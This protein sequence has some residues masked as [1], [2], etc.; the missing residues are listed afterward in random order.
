MSNKT[1]KSDALDR[2]LSYRE[3]FDAFIRMETECELLDRKT[4]GVCVWK[5]IRIHVYNQIMQELGLQGASHPNLKRG[6][7]G[8]VIKSKIDLYKLIITRNA[9]TN[10]E[11][12]DLLVF[13]HR[14]RVFLDGE[15]VEVNTEFLDSILSPEELGSVKYIETGIAQNRRN[16]DK[17]ARFL[18]VSPLLS[19]I[20]QKLCKKNELYDFSEYLENSIANYFNLQINTSA[21][22]T[23][24]YC[25]FKLT[26]KKYLDLLIK[27]T[28]HRVILVC[29]YGKESLVQ[30]CRD[31]NIPTIELQ[32]GIITEFHTGY[33]FPNR[34][35]V[36]Y[37]PDYIAL[38]G[39]Y[40]KET[41]L[42]P[43]PDRHVL[44]WGNP[45]FD[46]QYSN[47]IDIPKQAKSVLFISGGPQGE[48]LSKIS[49][50]FH[51][52]HPDYTVCYKLHPG[53]FGVW[54]QIYPHLCENICKNFTVVED[55]VNLYQLFAEYEYV[56]GVNSTALIESV[57]FGC[58]V[59]L[60]DK[61]GV[62]Y[63]ES[64]RNKFS[65]P[66]I[67][68]EKDLFNKMQNYKGTDRI[69]K[70]YFYKNTNKSQDNETKI[71]RC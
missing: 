17:N 22:V 29:S 70:E 60:L 51:K 31:L 55:M 39:K 44:I 38:H 20:Y 59:L 56:V 41:I 24:S 69:S 9:L 34:K 19:Y 49:V 64:F 6:S 25:A 14:R 68:D 21:V 40:W 1:R 12:Q 50:E 46:R 2:C 33:S 32:H 36:P 57:S 67:Q 42:L 71:H 13:R 18:L 35:N 23:K 45:Y 63:M 47:Y 65:I 58:R 52:K 15:Y 4:N 62:D 61:P 5:L 66:L 16:V 54:T 43:I 7:L 27:T 3:A 37:F 8:Q 30:A 28:P 48:A 53:E 26:Y 10:N 11:H